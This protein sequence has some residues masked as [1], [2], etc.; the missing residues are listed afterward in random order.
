M[1]GRKAATLLE[2]IQA[3]LA[4]VGEQQ[5]HAGL[6]L[7][8]C[9]WRLGVYV[10]VNLAVQEHLRAALAGWHPFQAHPRVAEGDLLG[11]LHNP[12]DVAPVNAVATL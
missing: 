3:F 11:V 12:V 2:I 7:Q 9:T 4:L 1:H 5:A 10:G 8:H 6:A